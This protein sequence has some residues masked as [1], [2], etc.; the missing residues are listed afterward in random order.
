[1]PLRPLLGL[2]IA[3]LFAASPGPAMEP[4]ELPPWTLTVDALLAA[5]HRDNLLL[6]PTN[7]ESSPLLRGEFEAMLLRAPTGAW[8]GYAFLNLEETRYLS[9]ENT[10]HERTVIFSTELRW[11]PAPAWKTGWSLQAYHQDLVLDVSVTDATLN[12]AQL[13]MTG[14]TTG[15]KVHWQHGRFSTE[16]RLAGRLDRYADD[17]DGYGE[18]S[19]A[20]RLGWQFTDAWELSATGSGFDRDHD[21]RTQHTLGGR[22]IA[23]AFLR[24]RQQETLLE[25]KRTFATEKPSHATLTAGHARSHD[26][27]SGYFDFERDLARLTL[28]ARLTGW[29][30]DLTLEFS[31][32][33]FPN[34][35]IGIGLNPDPRYK[36]DRRVR[37]ESVR[38]LNDRLSLLGF[39]EHEDSRSNDDRSRYRVTTLY[40]GVRW[41][42]DSLERLWREP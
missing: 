34:Q 28:H 38:R 22:P 35:L 27:G 26:N 4:I 36:H 31:R 7:A 40:A 13:R 3:T 11:K 14:F 24:T 6:S 39:V 1:M 2:G 8:D 5:G 25:L 23:G 42:W 18:Y 21:T 17:V 32:Y 20:L 16:L 9:G 33:E 29:T 19:G 12:T 10:D 41:S 37:L 30:H 15:P